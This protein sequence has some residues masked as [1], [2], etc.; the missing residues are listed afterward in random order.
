VAVVIRETFQLPAPVEQVWALLVDPQQVVTCMPGAA[1]DEVVDDRTFL[2]TIRVKVG[3]IVTSY[4]GRVMFTE[5]DAAG[6]RIEMSA[7]GKEAAGG[8]QARATMASH[9][10]ALPEGG[11]EVVA[12][13][14]AEITGRIMQFG[15]SMIEGVSHQLMLEFVQRAKQRLAAAPGITAANPAPAE[16]ISII[17]VIART[18]WAAIRRVFG[19]VRRLGRRARE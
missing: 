4:K 2:G 16:P 6:R 10:A 13:A 3:P 8:G 12:E 18:V 11:T 7:E 1:L 17:G 19:R 9:L 5:V 14:R 15:Q